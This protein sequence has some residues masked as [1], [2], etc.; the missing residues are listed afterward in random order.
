MQKKNKKVRRNSAHPSPDSRAVF[1]EMGVIEPD[2]TPLL[3]MQ[4]G[5]V[6]SN[7]GPQDADNCDKCNKKFRTNTVPLKC[8]SCHQSFHSTSCSE[9]TRSNIEKL[10][11]N[12]WKD[13]KCK[14][15]R[16]PETNMNMN[17]EKCAKCQ[18]KFRKAAPV[19]CSKCLQSFHKISCTG[20]SRE[21]IEE[22]VK[23]RKEW[24]CK[25][26]R[27]GGT[28]V[29]SS[30]LEQPDEQQ[31]QPQ[32]ADTP[33]P[34]Q[35]EETPPP[36]QAN[37][38][39]CDARF[40]DKVKPVKCSTCERNFHKTTC[41]GE[42]RWKIDKIVRDKIPWSC[43]ECKNGTGSNNSQTNNTNSNAEIQPKKCKAKC[44][45]PIRKGIDFLICS[46]CESHFH[47]HQKC[48][49]MSRKQVETL[50]RSTWQCLE[51]QEAEA[52]PQPPGEDQ[53]EEQETRYGIRRTKINKMN[54]LQ[55]NID[56]VSS[57]LEELKLLLK[58]ED[59]DVFLLQE[60]K[61]ID[62]DKKPKIPGYS[63]L[64]SNR[65]Q[66]RG[67]EENRGGGLMIGIRHDTPYKEIDL[68][69]GK[70]PDNH[71]ESMSIEIPTAPH[72]KLRLTNV[73]IP[74]A[75]T[76]T[77]NVNENLTK[78]DN[79]PSTSSDMI[80]GDFNAHSLL[81]DENTRN[82]TPDTR[83]TKIENWLAETEMA[84][85]NTGIPTYFNRSTARQSA[86]D[87]SF[88]HSSL[89][90]K[91]EWK[92]LDQLG[93]DHKPVVISYE[94]QMTK[95]NN[96]PK[97]KWKLT[98]ADWEKYS[99]EV[100]SSIP[101][102][103]SKM[104][105]NKLERKLRKAMLEAAKNH[106]GKKKVTQNSK[107]WMTDEIKEAIR[108]RNQLR[109]TVGQNREEWI[110]A[111]RNTASMIANRKKELWTEYVDLITETTDSTQVWK[112]I[113]S[114]DGRRPPSKDNEVL[115]VGE[116]TYVTDKDK[117]EQFAKTYKGFSKLPVKRE[118]RILR[119][120]N[121]TRMKRRPTAE[122]E[123]EQVFTMEEMER[124][125]KEAKNNKAAGEDDIPYEM[126]KNLG[127]KAR[128]L[129]LHLYNRCW[130]G[131][132]I[133]HKWRTAIIKPLLKE[134]KDPK[135]T[136]S[137]RPISLTSCMGKLLEKIVADRLIHILETRNLLNDNQA[138][139]RPNRC[140]TDQIL[141]LVQ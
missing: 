13:W 16:T 56:T 64:I 114:I 50:N 55:Y 53:G 57:K 73:Y 76:S 98:S 54:I 47:K 134:G 46:K 34:S 32:T 18:Q 45:N 79:W 35:E 102:E 52:P 25:N 138:G 10:R 61:M 9:E 141:K 31:Q 105:I 103:Y 91:V 33:T 51:C 83:G 15:C 118:D 1:L 21:V 129:L 22:V 38:G 93:S 117:A 111:C 135:L 127:P 69:I 24:T 41:T 59:I 86:P 113:R 44:G 19:K 40:N 104:K 92:T 121:R 20:E 60:T 29:D 75:N 63:V 81:W 95:V 97:Y 101:K 124:V 132:G 3:L 74:P 48:S 23:K 90:D 116:K 14:P 122:E 136:V 131:E 139:F 89:L 99:Q 6:E 107:P 108:E 106:V 17:T 109:K 37:C 133:P 72:K 128:E 140:T 115:Q 27:G 58:E 8:N 112:T 36:Q 96:K 137:Y 130:D 119:R 26:C 28:N 5:D 68:K 78:T 7:P 67:N 125:I 94:D 49:E 2:I 123:S 43:K 100:E 71:T 70:N 12:G 82:G 84:C 66:T 42:T 39:G 65:T 4:A 87:I 85:M 88:D 120:K 11:I 77:G 126:I 80:L 30:Q 62:S 110:E